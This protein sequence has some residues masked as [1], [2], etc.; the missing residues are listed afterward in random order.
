MNSDT[1]GNGKEVVADDEM[2]RTSLES[3]AYGSMQGFAFGS[4]LG[5]V[6]YRR[7]RNDM[8]TSAAIRRDMLSF[9]CL[10]RG[11]EC[12]SLFL[13]YLSTESF[14]KITRKKDDIVNSITAGVAL[15]LSVS[16][17]HQFQ[18][19]STSSSEEFTQTSFN[20]PIKIKSLPPRTTLKPHMGLLLSMIKSISMH[21]VGCGVAGA[22]IYTA[23]KYVEQLGIDSNSSLIAN[24]LNNKSKD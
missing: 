19:I 23:T 17:Y 13:I 14:M 12:S 4:F 16:V 22:M 9:N 6:D 2:F 3:I 7:K 24:I 1:K 20:N 11:M 21:S 15:G 10:K 18:S 5:V 8:N